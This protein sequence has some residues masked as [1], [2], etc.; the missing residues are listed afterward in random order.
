MEYEYQNCQNYETNGIMELSRRLGLWNKYSYRMCNC[1]LTGQYIIKNTSFLKIQY[2]TKGTFFSIKVFI[3]VSL[4]VQLYCKKRC[5]NKRKKVLAFATNYKCCQT[6]YHIFINHC[7]SLWHTLI[8]LF[9]DCVR[10]L[11]SP[12][13]TSENVLTLFHFP[14]S[15]RLQ[16][17][18]SSNP[19]D[20]FNWASIESMIFYTKELCKTRVR[21]IELPTWWESFLTYWWSDLEEKK[22]KIVSK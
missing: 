4:W 15:L 17:L 1:F 9:Q 18:L 7:I 22:K 6:V 2:L 3:L 16:F 20:R 10:R 21:W 11:S 5:R 14:K 8:S 13:T 12:F 19:C